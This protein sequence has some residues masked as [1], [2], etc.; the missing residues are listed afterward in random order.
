MY[1]DCLSSKEMEEVL[2]KPKGYFKK[3]LAV[4]KSKIRIATQLIFSTHCE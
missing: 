1:F 2:I 3:L 4:K